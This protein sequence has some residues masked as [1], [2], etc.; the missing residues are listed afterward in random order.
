MYLLDAED[1]TIPA[2]RN[3]WGAI[4]DSIVVVGGDGLWNCHIHTNDIGGAIEAGID[5]GRPRNVRVTDLFEQVEEEQWV[6]E[7]DVVADLTGVTHASRPPSSRSASVTGVRRLLTSLGV[8][9]VV[10]GGQSMNPS[11]AQILEAVE[12]CNA[13]AVI[14]L[15]NNK[16]IVAVAKQVDELTEKTVLV[17]ATHSVPEALAALVEYDPNA[18]CDANA[19]AMDA[20]I[21]RVRTGEVTQ[22]VRDAA[23][24]GEKVR[25]GDWIALTRDGMVAATGSPADAVCKLLE[26]LVDD[27]S[28]IVTV[29]VGSDAPAHEPTHPRA[30][31]VPVPARRGR[32]PRRRPAPVPV[33]RRRGVTP[34]RCRELA[35]LPVRELA[36][37][38][39]KLEERLADMGIETVLDVLQH[40]PRRWVDRTEK[41]DIATLAVGEEATVFAE[42]RTIHGRRTRQGRALVEAVVYDGTSVLNITFFNQAWREKQLSVGTEASFFGKLDV[43]RGKR[44]MTNPV[45]DVV[46]RAGEADEKTGVIVPVY[47][48]SGKAEVFTWQLRKIVIEALRRCAKRGLADPLDERVLDRLDLVRRDV[49]Y[50]GIHAPETCASCTPPNGA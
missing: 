40:Y 8:Q 15:P 49:A 13:S 23:I 4:G 11:T 50:R 30:H 46:G 22:A 5:A 25:A 41:A 38:G 3:A 44:Q 27:D 42:V 9:Q 10:A 28:E 47:P 26:E 24:D 48:Q 12:A 21:E 35:D 33:P 36:S 39:P 34:S 14:V 29:L 7:A 19:S 31:R 32:V 18:T 2:F 1:T 20:A 6:R 45:V 16:N 37:V 17:I 43:Y